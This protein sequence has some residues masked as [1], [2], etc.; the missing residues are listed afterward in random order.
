MLYYNYKYTI[1]SLLPEAD[2]FGTLVIGALLP[3]VDVK[4]KGMENSGWWWDGHR[5]TQGSKEAAIPQ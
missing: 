4:V 3:Q 5:D 2:E 1:C